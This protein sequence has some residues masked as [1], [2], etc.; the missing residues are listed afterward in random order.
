M[1]CMSNFA[2]LLSAVHELPKNEAYKL[3]VIAGEMIKRRYL[4]VDDMVVE[5]P[6]P[7]TQPIISRSIGG[8]IIDA[9]YF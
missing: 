2:V 6:E 3:C 9:V 5:K 1:G 8:Y 4:P 7:G